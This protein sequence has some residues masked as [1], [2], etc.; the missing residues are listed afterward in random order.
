MSIFN[1]NKHL[2]IIFI[3]CVN[4]ITKR[5]KMNEKV[6]MI[7]EKY[8]KMNLNM[9][10]MC[11]VIGISVSTATKLFSDLGEAQILKRKL[12]P[13]W[14]KIGKTRLWS[15]QGIIE[16]NDGTEVKTA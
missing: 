4:Y 8:Q 11:Q 2:H 15:I 12:L 7:Y 1:I 6:K 13:K 9:S 10:E 16:W 3:F 14:R 5:K